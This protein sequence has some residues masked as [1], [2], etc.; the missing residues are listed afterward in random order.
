MSDNKLYDLLSDGD[1]IPWAKRAEHFMMLKV[2]SGGLLP[3]ELEEYVAF[4]KTTL[5]PTQAMAATKTAAEVHPSASPDKGEVADA[6]RK[7]LI[8]GCLCGIFS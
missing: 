8:N 6:A 1:G 3:G 4:C 7:G 2:A 5:T